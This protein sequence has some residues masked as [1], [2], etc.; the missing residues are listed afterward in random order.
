ATTSASAPKA[1]SPAAPA[2]SPA[3]APQAATAPAASPVAR[4]EPQGRVVYGLDFTLTPTWLDPQ[5]NPAA[6]SPY[7][8]QYAIHDALVKHLPGKPFSPSLAESFEMA[9]DFKSATF[10]LREGVKFHDGSP[11]TPADVK[12][13]FENYKGANAKALKDKT[14]GIDTPDART[15]QFTFTEPFLDFMML[16]GTPASGAG[17]IVP[18]Q[19]YQQVGPDGFKQ[20]PIGAGPYKFVSFNGNDLELE[21][22]TDYWRATRKIRTVIFKAVAEDATRLAQLQ[23]GEA[24]IINL[25]PGPLLDTV[26]A[27]PNLTLAPVLGSA[28]W[29]EFPGWEKPD[30][31]FNNPKVRQ[32][33][34]LALDRQAISQA[35]EGGLSGFEG[36]WIPADWPGAIQRPMPEYNVDR[37]KQLMAEAGFPDGFDGGH[38]TPLPPYFSLAER[39][40][41]QLREIGI[42]TQLQ[43]MERGA[44]T[45]KLAEG[46]EAFGK[47]IV[48]QIS[49]SPGDAAARIRSFALCQGANSRT[50]VPEIDEKFARYEASANPQ[51]RE[52]L[53]TEIQNQFLDQHIF[54]PLYR[55]AFIN[56]LGPRIGGNKDEIMG[57]IPQ[58]VYVGPWEDVTLKP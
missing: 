54:V 25:I 37:A 13:T 29:L 24:D 41:T 2:A 11:V 4:A 15:V 48:L 47:G 52:Q 40:S 10:R 14:A 36:N 53:L 8:I 44:F 12:F 16:Y 17:W 35:E 55:Q 22:F 56:A 21:A 51:E 39:V 42:R 38:I 27:D 26:K 7:S 6:L 1:A 20:K 5:E 23:T 3:T 33:V 19:Y 32:A 49:A 58:Y 28:M 46:P 30:S 43:Q 34:N 50:C 45:A 31:P 57:S 18:A 9:T